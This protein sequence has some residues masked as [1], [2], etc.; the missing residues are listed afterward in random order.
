VL[1]L[2]TLGS[3]VAR[4]GR[5]F[6]IEVLAWSQ[7]LT[8]ERAAEVSVRRVDRDELL[9]RAD[10]VSIPLVLSERTRGLIGAGELGLMKPTAYL[11]N[12]SRDPIVDEAALVRALRDGTIAG[13]GLDVFDEEPERRR[14][15][16]PTARRAEVPQDHVPREIAR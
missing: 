16:R 15:G 2:G 6:E 4:V 5:A 14:D 3:R 8:A 13:A 7:H 12:T 9:A 10:V 1:G 11:V